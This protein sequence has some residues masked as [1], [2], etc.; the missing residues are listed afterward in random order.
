MLNSDTWPQRFTTGTNMP[1]FRM[2]PSCVRYQYKAFLWQCLAPNPALPQCQW[3]PPV[4]IICL[5]LSLHSTCQ[6]SSSWGPEHCHANSRKL[7][8]SCKVCSHWLNKVYSDTGERT[9]TSRVHLHRQSH[10]KWRW[11][12]CGYRASLNMLPS[13]GLIVKVWLWYTKKC[14]CCWR[15]LFSFTTSLIHTTNI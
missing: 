11:Y 12:Y 9:W 2:H 5:S 10:L 7:Q 4:G 8:G 13:S 14:G 3:V 15:Q 1:T 6:H